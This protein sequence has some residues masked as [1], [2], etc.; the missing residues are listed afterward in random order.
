MKKLDFIIIGA[1]KGGTT[2]LHMYLK[3]HPEIYMPSNKEAPFFSLDS[4]YTKGWNW[5]VKEYFTNA[6]DDQVWGKATPHYMAD[7]R[8]PQ[9]IYETMPDVKLIAVL[10][11]PIDRA[12]SH[13]QMSVRRG[14]EK[15]TFEE[16]MHN[17]LTTEKLNY[18]RSLPLE[19][20][21]PEVNC[22]LAW[23]EYGRILEQYQ[24]F[25]QQKILIIFSEDLKKDALKTLKIILN[26]I[27]V[28]ETVYLPN[29]HNHYHTSTTENSIYISKN[30]IIKDMDLLW[31]IW[32]SIPVKNRWIIR[33]IVEYVLNKLNPNDKFEILPETR[34]QLVD[35]YREDVRFLK[36]I[37]DQEI[38]WIDFK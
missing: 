29:L 8:V 25:F 35:F 20:I 18:A 21:A 17:L 22:Y 26:F 3:T 27:E 1:Q 14:W 13:Y 10:R 31:L 24:Y 33:R 4:I 23:G 9:R 34:N 38:P 11:N 32:K 37:V 16:A 12:F 5:Y 19:G 30:T 6:L 2:S 7:P 15:R 28:D 36:K